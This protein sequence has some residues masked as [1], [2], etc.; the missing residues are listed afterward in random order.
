[1]YLIV[2]SFDTIQ[3]EVT[4]LQLANLNAKTTTNFAARPDPKDLSG[5]DVAFS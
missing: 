5:R 2:I 3:C 1:M 4:H